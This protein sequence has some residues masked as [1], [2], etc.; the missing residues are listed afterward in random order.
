MKILIA[1]HNKAKLA[2]IRTGLKEVVQKKISIVSLGD[3]DISDVPEEIGNTFQ[4]NSFLKAKYYAL[5]SGLLTIA[6]DGGLIIPI[7]GNQPGVKSRRWP[8][9]EATDKELIIFTLNK[10]LSYKGID[11]KAYLQT[12]ITF[13]D[14]KNHSSFN[15]TEK[16]EGTIALKESGKT[17]GGYPYRSLFIVSANG[18]YYDELSK[19]EHKEINH[20]L[21]A[22]KRLV[23]KIESYLL[24]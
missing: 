20:R 17:T 1:T 2:E 24:Q 8:G 15:E 7:L 5:L 9:Y 23:K 3:L 6:D 16:I 4:E 13:Y 14:P 12:C 11:R 18:K 21:K 10:L 19:K 22:L